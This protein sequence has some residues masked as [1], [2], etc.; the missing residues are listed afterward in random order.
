MYLEVRSTIKYALDVKKYTW[1]KLK[2]KKPNIT[3]KVILEPSVTTMVKTHF[4]IDI[5]TLW[6]ITI[7]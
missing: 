3:T 2:Q 1:Q 4:E 7:W 6:H 5:V